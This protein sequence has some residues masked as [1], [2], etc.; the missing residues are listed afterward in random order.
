MELNT[1]NRP[2]QIASSDPQYRL[3]AE[4]ESLAAMLGPEAVRTSYHEQSRGAE[5]P[6]TVGL[7]V[8]TVA[9]VIVRVSPAMGDGDDGQP[10]KQAVERPV[11]LDNGELAGGGTDPDT[12]D[13]LG[14]PAG[15]V[16]RAMVTS[17]PAVVMVVSVP[18]GY[19]DD[20]APLDEA[21]RPSFV[22][23]GWAPPRALAA[24]AAEMVELF[25][26]AETLWSWCDHLSH[27]IL[28]ATLAATGADSVSAGTR[29]DS[30]ADAVVRL[31]PQSYEHEAEDVEGDGW[32]VAPA[33]HWDA[34]DAV[35]AN[36]AA[37]TRSVWTVC[38]VC[39][40]E[41]MGSEMTSCRGCGRSAV[42]A[43]CAAA[44]ARVHIDAGTIEEINCVCGGPLS[45]HTVHSLVD[46]ERAE[47]YDRLCL[48][49]AL[50]R[51]GDLEYCPR[52][53]LASVAANSEDEEDQRFG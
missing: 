23:D 8:A 18:T 5:P 33:L 51:M 14:V 31:N 17:L 41:R 45:V 22:L 46:P 26:G 16:E 21:P 39:L 3:A 28:P 20:C 50:N 25:D 48:T 32:R 13:V 2:L 7:A 12:G 53:E 52:C 44:M 35:V 30:G 49:K 6:E 29:A 36:E 1:L 47:K 40:S 10:R 15:K 34:W 4:L 38:A 27:Q 19:P 42:C 11:G 9:T 43:E 37:H 24:V